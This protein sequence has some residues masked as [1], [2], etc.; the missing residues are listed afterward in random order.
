[1]FDKYNRK[2]DY[3]RFSITDR[4]NH[5]C[6]YCMPPDVKF[7]PDDRLLTLDEIRTL[8]ET[9]S[10]LGIEQVRITGGEPLLREDVVHITRE[11]AQYFRVSM[12][13]NGVRLKELAWPLKEAG[14][15]SVNVSLN[16]LNEDVFFTITKGNVKPVLAGIDF[17]IECGLFVKVNTV[18]SQMNLNELPE[19]VDFA[20]KRG[21]PI[22]FIEMMPI[23]RQN[24][25]VI[26]EDQIL[27][28]LSDF[29]LRPV[30]V[31]LGQGPA[32]YFV[33][34][35]GNYVGIIS[36]MSKSFCE[37]CNKLRLS[38]D[39]KLYPCLGSTHYVDLLKSLR[40][41]DHRVEQLSELIKIAI[42]NK[43]LSH[44]MKGSAVDNAMNRLGG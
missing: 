32:K 35:Y 13:T 22:R 36:A 40:S 42:Y 30:Q 23:G 34:K 4:C 24:R 15:I 14:L 33:T 29:D 27:E 39:G 11:L 25:G 6:F 16:S 12:T 41:K 2:I 9:F 18:V 1:M 44:Q 21:I 28:K 7:L 10:H 31:K 38:C 8:A 3:L 43:P 20:S 5:R 26:F 19:L 17:A 37:D